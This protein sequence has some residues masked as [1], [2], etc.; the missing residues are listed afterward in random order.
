LEASLNI[1]TNI[2]AP[3]AVTGPL[4]TAVL[5]RPFRP[6]VEVSALSIPQLIVEITRE[7]D[8]AD[9]QTIHSALMLRQLRI[10]V[11]AGELG[12]NVN[13]YE[14]ALQ[15]VKL[16]KSRLKEL[17][18]IARAKDPCVELNYLRHLAVER[19]KRHKPRSAID[20]PLSDQQMRDKVKAFARKASAAQLEILARLCE[21]MPALPKVLLFAKD[22]PVDQVRKLYEL[23]HNMRRLN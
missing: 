4:A 3:T 2:S 6:V 15:A 7:S 11:Q 5:Q 10:R 22:G 16:S 19:A 12:P 1:E 18:K 23:V 20:E 17:D 8:D 14:Y 13:W 9:D 21:P